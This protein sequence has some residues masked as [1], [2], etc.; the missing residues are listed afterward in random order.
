M[1]T[2]NHWDLRYLGLAEH[3][4]TW[5]KDPSTQTGSVITSPDNRVVSVGFNGLPRGITDTHERLHNRDLKYKL[6]VHCER[7]ALLFAREDLT[8]F[9]LYTWPFM[10]CSVC[11]GMVVQSGIK[12]CV[13]PDLSVTDP[14]RQERWRDD[15]K[16]SEDIF[17][18]AGIELILIPQEYYLEGIVEKYIQEGISGKNA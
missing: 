15:M 8:G 16:L 17:A 18:E 12:R 10:S 2:W 5:S 6:I 3:V 13:A 14:Q 7:N 4:A 11:A 9:T 1:S